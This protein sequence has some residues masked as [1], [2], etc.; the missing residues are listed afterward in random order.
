ML[1]PVDASE[2]IAPEALVL[3]RPDE[4]R[5]LHRGYA[6]A[7]SH[8]VLTCTFG[9]TRFRLAGHDLQDRVEEINRRAAELAREVAQSSASTT[10]TGEVF[11][12]GDMGPTGQLLTPLG[13]LTAEDAAE[14]YAEQAGALARGGADLL[15]VETMSDLDEAK[16]AIEGARRATDLPI[17]CTFTFDTH[18]RTMMGVSP[19]KVAHEIG[20]LAEGIGANCGKEPAEY[21]EIMRVMR[22]TLDDA[23]HDAFLWAKPNA[24]LPR[25]VDDKV[26]YDATSEYMGQ[27]AL[28]LQE[29]GAQIVGGCCGTTPEY[30]KSMTTA[31]KNGN[32]QLEAK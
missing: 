32:T 18:G 28:Q 12:V 22:R 19:V 25:L 3:E 2:T 27:I 6:R 30:I 15:L 1:Q 7:G 24:G 16:A 8:L 14:A 10:D 9:G 23:G 29:A 17:V 11:V 5:A 20:P 31:L 4:I 21:V 26:I 13:T